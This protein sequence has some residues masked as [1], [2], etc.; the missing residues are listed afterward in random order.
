MSNAMAKADVMESVLAQGNLDVLST[1]QRTNYY[2]KVCES[3]GLNPATRPF[4]YI[5]MQGKTILYARRDCTEQLRK[6]DGVSVRISAREVVNGVYVVTAQASRADGRIDESIGAVPIEGLKG[7]ALSNA[8]MKAETKAKRR[9]TLSICGL[10]FLDESEV[11]AGETVREEI[12]YETGEVK[13]ITSGTSINSAL[14]NQLAQTQEQIKRAAAAFDAVASRSDF[15]ALCTKLK[16]AAPAVQ[17]AKDV[18]EA[19]DR[20]EKRTAEAS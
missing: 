9:V 3:L 18:V 15:D 6:R 11:S 4:E 19:H 10:G 20:A 14:E 12:N 2:L 13:Q 1:E 16:N 5:K 7:E 17:N 8:M